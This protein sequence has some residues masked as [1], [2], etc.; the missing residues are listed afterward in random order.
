VISVRKFTIYSF[1]SNG[2]I[3]WTTF[4]QLHRL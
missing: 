3:C 4:L 1:N 2:V